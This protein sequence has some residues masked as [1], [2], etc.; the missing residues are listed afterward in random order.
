MKLS[1]LIKKNIYIYPIVHY[2]FSPISKMKTKIKRRK[3][4]EEYFNTR[5]AEYKDKENHIWYL[6]IPE[7]PNLGDQAQRYCTYSWIRENFPSFKVYDIITEIAISDRF[8]E[9][10]KNNIGEED[11]IIFQSGY[12]S[13]D[14]HVDHWMHLKICENIRDN[15]TVFLPQTVNVKKRKSINKIKK[16]LGNR[17]NIIFLARDDVSFDMIRELI[18]NTKV[19]CYP[20]IVTTLIGNIDFTSPK[21]KKGI[22]VCVR[23]DAEKYFSDEEINRLL[24]TLKQKYSIV[25][26]GDT[27]SSLTMS[28]IDDNL[29]NV[30]REMIEEFS[31]YSV[32]ITDRYHGTIF[33]LISNTPV[34]VL[35]T[36]DHKVIT[37]VNWFSGIY[38]EMSVVSCDG[39]DD[40]YNLADYRYNSTIINKEYFK[41]N[42]YD[43][44]K[45]II[46]EINR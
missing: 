35:K 3:Q 46:I 8:V 37:G 30:I 29:E 45:N 14:G 6:G 26:I 18:G 41:S 43:N 9:W 10:L 40:V 20:D 5:M 12:C 31:K 24:R 38:D 11:L 19:Y 34:I 17:K 36:K 15:T 44:L 13:Q 7:H 33:S 22:F 39:I 16:V 21:E 2:L 28:D 25:N 23:N 4:W 42:Y 32:I 27:D 1:E